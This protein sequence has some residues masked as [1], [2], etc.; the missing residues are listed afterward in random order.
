M[1]IGMASAMI[2]RRGSQNLAALAEDVLREDKEMFEL[3]E[4]RDFSA[5]M[6]ST[7]LTEMMKRRL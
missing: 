1:A 7:K 4:R 5:A 2:P 6:L 3:T